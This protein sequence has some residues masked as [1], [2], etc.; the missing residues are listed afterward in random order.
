MG[1]GDYDSTT[2]ASRRAKVMEFLFVNELIACALLG[3]TCLDRKLFR[4]YNSK[5]KEV[6]ACEKDK[7]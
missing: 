4:D 5:Y 2:A 6:T 3:S 7:G 1:R